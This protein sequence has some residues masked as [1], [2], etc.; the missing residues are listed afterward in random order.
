MKKA[1]KII[2]L[3]F[4]VSFAI[5]IL[6]GFFMGFEAF[7]RSI[8]QSWRSTVYETKSDTTY[9][10]ERK[11]EYYTYLLDSLLEVNPK[12]AE[13]FADKLHKK[14]IEERTFTRY[15][16]ISLVYQEKFEEAIVKFKKLNSSKF[17]SDYNEIS[18][19]IGICYENL[20]EYDSAIHYYKESGVHQNLARIYWCYEKDNK[21]DSAIYYLEKIQKNLEQDPNVLNNIREIDFVDRKLDS[22]KKALN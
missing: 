14:Y 22:L 17:F 4:I 2:A 16:V 8:S 9:Q 15:K 20:K 7:Q 11:I 13:L 18:Y 21:I 19:D 6:V 1:F 12:Q 3:I 10:Y 5:N